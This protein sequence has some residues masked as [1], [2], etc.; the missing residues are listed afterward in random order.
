MVEISIER[1]QEYTLAIIHGDKES[2]SEFFEIFQP[3][4]YNFLYRYTSNIDDARD[5]TQEAFVRFWLSREKLVHDASPLPYLF[6]IAKNLAL[7]LQSRNKH[8][9][10]IDDDNL[11]ITLSKNPERSYESIFMRDEI[12]KAISS[13]PYRCRTTFI[14]SRY[15]GFNYSEIAEI[16]D[17]SLQTVKNQMNKAISV[18]R[19]QLSHLLS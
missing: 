12:Q 13:L 15:N 10:S 2:F 16:M 19:K 4:V 6:T 5:L 18:L 3:S 17:V 7:N 9:L 11:L 1:L 8:P 14:L